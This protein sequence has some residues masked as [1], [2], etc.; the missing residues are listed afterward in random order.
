MN[1]LLEALPRWVGFVGFMPTV[2]L[3]FL[4]YPAVRTVMV[5][6][7]GS[8]MRDIEAPF[9]VRIQRWQTMRL[10]ALFLGGVA[11]I[12]AMLFAARRTGP[13][14]LLPPGPAALLAGVLSAALAVRA[15][16]DASARVPD[17]APGSRGRL[18]VFLLA[19]L[20]VP[21]Y[22]LSCGLLMPEEPGWPA[23]VLVAVGLIPLF[24][25]PV[26]RWAGVSQPASERLRHVHSQAAE[27]HGSGATHLHELDIPAANAMAALGG[28]L[29]VTT[30]AMRVLND[31]ELKAVLLHELGHL[32]ESRLIWAFRLLALAFWLPLA[33]LVPLVVR[34]GPL[35]VLLGGLSLL[36]LTMLHQLFMRRMEHRADEAAP[37]E[38]LISALEKLHRVNHQPLAAGGSHPGVAERAK[39]HGVKFDAP[40][41]PASATKA[42]WVLSALV[43]VAA[44]TVSV[45]ASTQHRSA[46]LASETRDTFLVLSALAGGSSRDIDRMALDF[47]TPAVRRAAV[48]HYLE[49]QEDESGSTRAAWLAHD[50]SAACQ[51]A[52][53]W[54]HREPDD[55]ALDRV[56]ECLYP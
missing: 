38:A 25:V 45:A 33:F 4:V 10:V 55:D 53:T 27:A 13:F 35:V 6:A 36:L 41:P 51:Q 32:S 46:K 34:F 8:A 40:A 47:P 20:S 50:P 28:T 12:L 5:P 19:R 17:R 49:R 3:A 39:A 21:L 15:Y 48:R 24:K 37:G 42:P 22:F 7:V 26:L 54:L 18:T 1:A 9:S 11:T 30:A 31:D 44:M 43:V 14:F 16:F 52:R 23:V 56:A 29:F 2:L